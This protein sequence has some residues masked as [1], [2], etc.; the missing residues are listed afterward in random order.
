[1][2]LAHAQHVEVRGV[3]HSVHREIAPW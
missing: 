1:L 3:L 2:A